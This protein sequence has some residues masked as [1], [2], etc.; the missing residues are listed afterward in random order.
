[1]GPSGAIT[2][3]SATFTWTGTDNSTPTGAL[4]YAF[5]LDPIESSFSAFSAATSKTYSG[6]ANGSYTLLVK[7]KD[8][9]GNEDPSPASR[10]CAVTVPAASSAT[11][12]G[13]SKAQGSTITPSPG[14]VLPSGTTIETGAG[15]RIEGACEDGTR[16][17]VDSNSRVFLTDSPCPPSG[18]G[19]VD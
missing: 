7:A 8:R 5:R 11:G 9:A 18:V 16:F 17:T 2:T 13:L 3:N 12:S 15:G 14:A 19:I 10:S 6:L 4:V 1:T